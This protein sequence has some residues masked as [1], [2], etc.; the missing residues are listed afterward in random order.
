[1]VKVVV[2]AGGDAPPAGVSARVPPADL[3][4]AADS[5]LG[6]AQQLG[7]SVDLVVGDLDSV[8]DAELD[9]AV[10]AGAAVERHPPEKDATDLE[11]AL[12]AACARRDPHHD[13]RWSRRSTRPLPCERLAPRRAALSRCRY[14]RMGGRCARRRRV[15]NKARLTGDAGSLVTLLAAGGAAEGVT[16]DGLRYPLRGET[17]APGS[18]RGVSNELIGNQRRRVADIRS[19]PRNSTAPVGGLNDAHT[20]RAAP[21]SVARCRRRV[22]CRHPGFGSG[23]QHDDGKDRTSRSPS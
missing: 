19:S 3:V 2:L 21:R 22:R 12:D 1:M 15:R 11:L 20:H 8:D 5:G 18:T 6:L 4:I 17:L 16:T 10:A 14:R 13:R 23:G 7:L 9:A